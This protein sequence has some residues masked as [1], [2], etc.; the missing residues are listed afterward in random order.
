MELTFSEPWI[1]SA[2]GPEDYDQY[3]YFRNSP[4]L[5]PGTNR[6]E[7]RISAGSHYKVY[8]NGAYIGRGPAPS[9]P[10]YP[11]VDSYQVQIGRA[12]V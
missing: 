8:A 7:L 10:E 1:W 2:D 3:V 4:K 11:F 6:V 9:S 12:H 5:F